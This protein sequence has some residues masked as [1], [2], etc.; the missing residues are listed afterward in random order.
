MF[1]VFFRCSLLHGLDTTIANA[2]SCR[3]DSGSKF[4]DPSVRLWSHSYL[5]CGEALDLL[6]SKWPRGQSVVQLFVLVVCRPWSS[7]RGFDGRAVVCLAA[8]ACMLSICRL[9]FGTVNALW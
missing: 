9:C 1:V 2:V 4:W 5:T 6:L 8:A 7:H 3:G